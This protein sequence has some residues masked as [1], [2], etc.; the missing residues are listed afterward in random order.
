MHKNI[1]LFCLSI[2]LF[3]KNSSSKASGC[4]SFLFAYAYLPN[5]QLCIL[6][7][8]MRPSMVFFSHRLPEKLTRKAGLEVCK[9]LLHLVFD[10]GH[11]RGRALIPVCKCNTAFIAYILWCLLV[12]G[13]HT[14]VSYMYV[15]TKSDHLQACIVP[16][17]SINCC[18]RPQ[19]CYPCSMSVSH[20]IAARF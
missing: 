8:P 13:S 14:P 17:P 18:C 6:W 20:G 9:R 16:R 2:A 7:M 11:L 5:D 19:E 4:S 15:C 10:L 1:S 3:F 12:H